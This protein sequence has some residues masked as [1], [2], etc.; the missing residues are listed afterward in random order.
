MKRRLGY[1]A[2][3]V[4]ADFLTFVAAGALG[5]AVRNVVVYFTTVEPPLS[6]TSFTLP[7]FA[8]LFWIPL[9]YL[10][11][12]AYEGLYTVK[13]PYWEDVKQQVKALVLAL[14]LV[15]GGIS[16]WKLSHTVSR[17]WLM[18]TWLCAL[19]L[20]PLARYWTVRLLHRLGIGTRNVLIVGA[21]V[22]GRT[23]LKGLSRERLLGFSV[24]GFLDD[25]P[26][27][28]AA[29]F[30]AAGRE[31]GVLGTTKDA[32]RVCREHRVAT[33]VVAI[34]SLDSP[35][36][37][38]LVNELHTFTRQ[39]VIV[40]DLKG[41]SL[42]NC[43]VHGLFDEEIFLLDIRN[44]LLY[45]TNALT[46][47]LFDVTAGTFIFIGLTP[48]LAVLAILVK[49]TSPGPVLFGHARVGRNG[50]PFTAWKFRSMYRD[51]K[52]R[53]DDL[54]AKDPDAKAEWEAHFKLKNDPRVTPVGRFLRKTSLDEL[55]Q[56]FNVLSGTMSLVGPRPVIKEEIEKYYGDCA[57]YYLEVKPGITGLWQTSGRSDTG[58]GKRIQLDKWYVQN[59]SLWLD[60][61]LLIRTIRVVV[62]REGA[63]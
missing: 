57:D 1:M 59:W 50:R 6:A 38:A 12:F 10:S 40:P 19:P 5:Y 3:L 2:A 18:A 27:K 39:I 61:V 52:E 7:W 33:V 43:D 8:K 11:A 48:V 45:H 62:R 29:K 24:V 32:E 14:F 55:P 4:T 16:L 28:A 42:S 31:V 56:I 22:A 30:S 46:K 17:L 26:A 21:G 36:L 15:F 54:L 37:G 9:I 44:N 34:P 47:L 41:V 49:V 20:F 51:A 23:A 25:D 60:I 35:R 63:Y 58:Y 53:L 13:L